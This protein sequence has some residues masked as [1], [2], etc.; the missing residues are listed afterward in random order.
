MSTPD[1]TAQVLGGERV[2]GRDEVGRG[3]G[4]HHLA[5]VVSG[6]RAD[7]LPDPDT[8]VNTVSRRL[9]MSRETSA[10][11]F[12]LAPRTS[13]TSWLSRWCDPLYPWCLSESELPEP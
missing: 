2:S 6:A 13:I 4:E 12:S 11:L 10:R 5:T 3:T 9:G 7:D 8:P 1:V